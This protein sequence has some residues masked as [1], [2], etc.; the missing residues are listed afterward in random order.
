MDVFFLIKK[1]EPDKYCDSHHCETEGQEHRT[2]ERRAL[3]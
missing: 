2:L 1:G 3:L